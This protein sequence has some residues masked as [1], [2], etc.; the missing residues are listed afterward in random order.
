MNIILILAA[1][2]PAILF[3]FVY[4]LIDFTPM[5][6][7]WVSWGIINISFVLG[8]IGSFPYWKTRDASRIGS[9]AVLALYHQTVQLIIGALLI[10]I[11]CFWMITLGV[12][13][14]VHLLV[15]AIFI[16]IAAGNHAANV[17]TQKVQK[18]SVDSQHFS[19]MIT[20]KLRSIWSNMPEGQNKKLVE[21]A[22][23]NARTMSKNLSVI[24]TDVDDA[25]IEE[26]ML[27][28]NA[29]SEADE[30]T[31]TECCKNIS[32]MINKRNL[33]VRRS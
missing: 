2:I 11:N 18:E 22:Y 9:Q 1:C 15:A 4:F 31:I 5:L 32:V 14:F 8:I 33:L 27:L 3:N 17:H 23:D 21:R 10:V 20:D 25:I 30:Q 26:L 29:V 16:M 19:Q 7:R 28:K 13:I 24:K 12:T 6:S